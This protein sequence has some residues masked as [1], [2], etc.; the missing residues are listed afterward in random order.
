VDFHCDGAGARRQLPDAL[1]CPPA[2]GQP[3]LTDDPGKTGDD[4]DNQ[5]LPAQQR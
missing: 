2:E 4:L 5:L 3:A 1:P